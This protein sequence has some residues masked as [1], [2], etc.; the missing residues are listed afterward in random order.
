[1]YQTMSLQSGSCSLV[2]T[3]NLAVCY[4]NHAISPSALAAC[5]IMQCNGLVQIQQKVLVF[6]IRSLLRV[7][8]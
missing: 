6:M 4:Y 7:G 5:F 1:M 8:E 2:A 3:F